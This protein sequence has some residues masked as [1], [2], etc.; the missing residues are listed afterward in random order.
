MSEDKWAENWVES[1]GEKEL[2]EALKKLRSLK[3]MKKQLMFKAVINYINSMVGE[4][5]E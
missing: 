5:S 3:G 1:E 4:A 2:D